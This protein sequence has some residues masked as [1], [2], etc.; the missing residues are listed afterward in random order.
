MESFFVGLLL[1]VISSMLM[2]AWLVGNQAGEI[3]L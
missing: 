1:S 2:V 3:D